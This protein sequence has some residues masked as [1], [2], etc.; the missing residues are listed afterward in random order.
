[1]EEPRGLVTVGRFGGC[2]DPGR[3]GRSLVTVG[4]SE[5]S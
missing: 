2:G 1:M 5:G 3:T 4:G